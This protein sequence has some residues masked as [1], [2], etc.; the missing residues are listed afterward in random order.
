MSRE[1]MIEM[2]RVVTTGYTISRDDALTLIGEEW[3]EEIKEKCKSNEAILDKYI[4]RYA[5]RVKHNNEVVSIWNYFH[6]HDS[7][8][9][10]PIS[11]RLSA[12]NTD[13]QGYAIDGTHS[14]LFEVDD[15]DEE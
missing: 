1:Y 14:V 3:D 11:L 8:F 15:D 4:T 7:E 9:G 2:D 10:F 6:E 13:N 12:E 5:Q